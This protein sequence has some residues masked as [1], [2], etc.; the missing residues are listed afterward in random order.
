ML[1]KGHSIL[2]FGDY[3][4]PWA[5][6]FDRIT[7]QATSSPW[8]QSFLDH[9]ASIVLAETRQMD[10]PL[11][12]SLMVRGTGF[13]LS[14]LAELADSY[15]GE[16]DPVG[17]VD[18]VMVYVMGSPKP[19]SVTRGIP[20]SFNFI[21]GASKYNLNPDQEY[22]WQFVEPSLSSM[23]E[24]A[25][26]YTPEEQESHKTWYATQVTPIFGGQPSEETPDPNPFTHDSSPCHISINWCSEGKPTVRSGMT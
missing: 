16:K 14:S 20:R 7:L 8:L 9:V 5:D 22:W 1:T 6:A 23:M 25:G 21:M 17:F 3:T 4:D 10:E 12:Q 13:M 19:G 11:R 15:R 26:Q 2:L 18:A 24:H